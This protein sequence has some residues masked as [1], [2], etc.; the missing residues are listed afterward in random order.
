MKLLTTILF[1]SFIISSPAQQIYFE[2]GK[3]ASDFDFSDSR[4]VEFENLQPTTQTYLGVGYR[5]SIF[6]ESLHVNFGARH[7]SYGAIASDDNRNNFFEWDVDYLGLSAGLDYDIACAGDFK[8]FIS[9]SGTYEFIIQG[10][11]T[12][13]NTVINATN[14]EEFEDNA[15]FF[16]AGA[17]VAYPISESTSVYFQYQ[18]GRS[19][20][21]E[22]NTNDLSQEELNI[23]AHMIGIGLRVN[24]SK[25]VD[26]ESTTEST[27]EE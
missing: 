15:I 2:T 16:R 8:F 9:G 19:L 20:A 27:N 12:I 6:T 11:Q 4:G 14:V 5:Q 13:N 18:Y 21:L 22:D 24:L 3:T 26:T 23:N 1:L 25:S 17:G 7:N 10:T